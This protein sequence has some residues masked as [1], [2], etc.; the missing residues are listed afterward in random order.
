MGGEIMYGSGLGEWVAVAVVAVVVEVWMMMEVGTDRV[1][2]V[3]VEMGAVEEGV[4][5]VGVGVGVEE[6]RVVVMVIIVEGRL[7]A[8]SE[9]EVEEVS[10]A[11]GWEE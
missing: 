5:G 4:V 8:V 2:S 6:G 9:P 10:E 11:V 3:L 7:V 1:V